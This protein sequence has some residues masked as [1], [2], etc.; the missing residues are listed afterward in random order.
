MNTK[1][2][3]DLMGA[4][5]VDVNGTRLY[6]EEA[7]SGPAVVLIHGFTLDTRMWDDQFLPLAQHFRVI[8]YDMRG[9]G[10]SAVPTNEPYSHVED[11]RALLDH[12]N[13]QQASL[14]GLSKGGGVALDFALSY[15][16][17]TQALA[18][19]D[20]ILGG[21]SWS[22]EGSGRDSL[23]W[24]EARRGGVAAAKVSWLA[25][26]LFAPALQQPATAARLRQIIADYSGWHFVNA[27]PEQGVAPPAGQRL[28]ELEMP[29]LAI[30]G[31]LDLPDFLQIT[32]L[33]SRQAPRVSKV[34][35]PDVG[36]MANMEAPDVV[37]EALRG[38]LG[39]NQ[40]IRSSA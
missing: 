8:R 22:P 38:F 24:Q 10:Q 13:V 12:L 21:F 32:E 9:F 33:I 37:T 11:L 16:Q 40:N 20:S 39:P 3:V 5:P 15:P 7:G 17:R 14:V 30:V 4:I 34:V 1:M 35:L 26:P 25:H 19:I 29:V 36:H 23:V 28:A 27:N 31:E 2:V 18:L 6:Y